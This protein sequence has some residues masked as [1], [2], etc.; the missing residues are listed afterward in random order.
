MRIILSLQQNKSGEVGGLGSG[1]A[2]FSTSQLGLELYPEL[3]P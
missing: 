3:E 1:C 2:V